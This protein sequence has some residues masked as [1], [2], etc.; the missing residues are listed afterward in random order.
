MDQSNGDLLF[1]EV[2]TGKVTRAQTGWNPRQLLGPGDQLDLRLHLRLLRRQDDPGRGRQLARP[3]ERADLRRQW[4]LRLHQN[5]RLRTD[6]GSSHHAQ[7]L[8]R[9]QRGIRLRLRRGGRSV[10]RQHLYRRLLRQHLALHPERPPRS[11]RRTTQAE[12][13]QARSAPA[14]SPLPPAMSTSISSQKKKSSSSRPAPS[15]SGRRRLQRAA[16]SRR[17]RHVGSVDG[18]WQRRR[19]RGP[20]QQSRGLRLE[21]ST[22]RSGP[23]HR[24]DLQLGRASRSGPRTITSSPT[25]RPRSSASSAS[26][27]SRT[28]RST[29]SALVH[30]VKQSGTHSYGDFQVTPDGQYAVLQQRPAADRL[31]RPSASAR[32]IATTP[33]RPKLDCA[34]CA[35]TGSRSDEQHLAAEVR[36]RADRRRPGV[37]H[38]P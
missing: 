33:S 36:P 20:G 5:I 35:S 30:G 22:D 34:S 27:R 11:P 7:R 28:R 26:N 19:L 1:P 3:G 25:G 32:F 29:T 21:R 10:Q 8:R 6:R 37:L 38:D 17:H 23:R 24:T 16:A 18:P 14:T 13:K 2:G 15:L 31:R 9:R 4:R 12:S